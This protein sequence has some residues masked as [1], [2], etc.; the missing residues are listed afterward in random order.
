MGVIPYREAGWTEYSEKKKGNRHNGRVG[1]TKWKR[2]GTEAEKRKVKEDEIDMFIIKYA[3]RQ[4]KRTEEGGNQE[5]EED[6]VKGQS[7][8]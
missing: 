6:K 2:Q 1:L 3:Q 7:F 5:E 8:F 4:L